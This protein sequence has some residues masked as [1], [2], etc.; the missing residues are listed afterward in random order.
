MAVFA[1][2]KYAGRCGSHWL[3][4]CLSSHPD[5]FVLRNEQFDIDREVWKRQEL[6]PDL[7]KNVF[8]TFGGH[9]SQGC[10]VKANYVDD[11]LWRPLRE[12][13]AR[14]PGIHIILNSRRDYLA[15]YVS[16]L[17]A[18]ITGQFSSFLDP[19]E[20]EPFI[21]NIHRMLRTFNNWDKKTEAYKEI[22]AGLPFHHFYYEDMER[23]LGE[24]MRQIYQFIGVDASHEP[25]FITKIQRLH[26]IEKMIRNFHMVAKAIED[27]PWV[28]RSS[29]LQ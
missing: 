10:L 13:I 18:S 20:A 29:D 4:S 23:D 6:W 3:K 7:I 8:D 27:S 25:A 12:E 1:V 2:I 9:E 5:V 16:L 15:Q 19:I 17:V 22:Y 28:S 24:T 11:P 14:V 21:I 26:K